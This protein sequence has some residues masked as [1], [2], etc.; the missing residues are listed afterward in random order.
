MQLTPFTFSRLLSTIF[1][2]AISISSVAQTNMRALIFAATDD[3][4]IGKGNTKSVEL[5][6]TEL[7]RIKDVTNGAIKPQILKFTGAKCNL[8]EFKKAISDLQSWDI[9]DDI[10]LFYFMGHGFMDDSLASPNLLF[11]N[12]K[13]PLS[14]G[15]ISNNNINLAQAHEQI[16]ALGARFTISVGEACNTHIEKSK[17]AQLVDTMNIVNNMPFGVNA[18]NRLEELFL[19]PEGDVML[20]SSLRGQYSFVSDLYGGIFTQAFIQAIHYVSSSPNPALWNQLVTQTKQIAVTLCKNAQLTEKQFPKSQVQINSLKEADKVEPD[21]KSKEFLEQV[22]DEFKQ[23][24]LLKKAMKNMVKGKM[25]SEK[26]YVLLKRSDIAEKNIKYQPFSHYLMLAKIGEDI[27]YEIGEVY[28]HYNVARS[29]FNNKPFPK[30]SLVDVKVIEKIEK[31]ARRKR[32]K[33]DVA[34]EIYEAGSVYKWLFAR[35][36]SLNATL[37]NM[38]KVKEGEIQD[39]YD[40]IATIDGKILKEEQKIAHI[41]EEMDSIRAIMAVNND[42]IGQLNLFKQARVS[43]SIADVNQLKK[44]DVN[45]IIPYLSCLQT[46]LDKDSCQA[47]TP[48]MVAAGMATINLSLDKNTTTGKLKPDLKKF[49]L[50]KYCD[51]SIE[52]ATGNLLD[53]LLNVFSKVPKQPEYMEKIVITGVVKGLA[54]FR[55]AGKLLNIR[56]KPNEDIYEVYSNKYGDVKDFKFSKGA[57]KR[58]TNEQLAFLRAYCAYNLIKDKILYATDGMVNVESE[59]QFDIDFVAIEQN[60][61]DT[62][63]ADRSRGVEIDINIEKLYEFIADQIDYFTKENLKLKNGLE[64]RAIA[65]Q[66]SRYKIK[67]LKTERKQILQEIDTKQAEIENIE[68]IIDKC[69]LYGSEVMKRNKIVN[70]KQI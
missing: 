40:F 41:N 33:N 22:A 65:R 49:K 46:K 12:T 9:S 50:G 34:N 37:V 8:S 62:K 17:D 67:G 11:Y 53:V 23:S 15:V 16:K 38:K 45:E 66:Q 56:F 7:E 44:S 58:I 24:K 27:E 31:L 42:T 26:I 57:S 18:E 20:Q 6:E 19:L 43:A 21:Y 3:T 60:K 13:G 4:Y 70:V 68:K 39:L 32:N 55:G 1:I 5:L 63:E 25:S 2:L 59:S 47:S 61:K 64:Q 14:K 54:D 48:A 29:L 69:G 52:A 51:A 35:Q 10:I 28:L 30:L 36:D